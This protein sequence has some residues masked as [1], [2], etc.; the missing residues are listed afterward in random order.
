MKLC[1]E[2]EEILKNFYKDLLHIY[3]FHSNLYDA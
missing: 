3:W 1:K 2:F